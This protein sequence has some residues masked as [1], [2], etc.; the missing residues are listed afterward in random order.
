MKSFY[1]ETYGCQMNV[2]DSEEIKALLET[3]GYKETTDMELADLII[4]N[5]CAVR[6]NAHDKVFGFLGRC[7]HA[8][9]RPPDKVLPDGSTDKLFARASLVI[10]SNNITTSLLCSTSLFALS[11]TILATLI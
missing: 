5:T 3:I 8:G 7:K 10:L 6:E 9:S 1:I 11:K 2:H 4:L